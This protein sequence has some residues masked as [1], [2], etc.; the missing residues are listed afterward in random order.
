MKKFARELKTDFK[1]RFS[2]RARFNLFLFFFILPVTILT[3]FMSYT[4]GLMTI[5]DRLENTLSDQR[6][7]F[8]NLKS[9]INQDINDVLSSVKSDLINGYSPNIDEIK[10]SYPGINQIVVEDINLNQEYEQSELQEQQTIKGSSILTYLGVF[11]ESAAGFFGEILQSRKLPE[12]IHDISDPTRTFDLFSKNGFKDEFWRNMDLT[13]TDEMYITVNDIVPTIQGVKFISVKVNLDFFDTLLKGNNMNTLI[14]KNEK[15]IYPK[16]L[17]D[18]EIEKDVLNDKMKLLKTLPTFNKAF[19]LDSPTLETNITDSFVKINDNYYFISGKEPLSILNSDSDE[20]YILFAIDFMQY[21]DNFISGFVFSLALSAIPIIAIFIFSILYRKSILDPI[22][23]LAKNLENMDNRS[24]QP[25][26][27]INKHDE[28]GLI[29]HVF[30]ENLEEIQAYSEELQA[31]NEELKISNE[32]LTDMNKLLTSMNSSL[33]SLVSYQKKSRFL[34]KMYEEIKS[35]LPI[36]KMVMLTQKK[37]E[38]E[39]IT[40]PIPFDFD[41][42]KADE[43]LNRINSDRSRNIVSVHDDKTIIFAYRSQNLDDT[44]YLIKLYLSDSL[45]EEN[46]L[47]VVEMYLKTIMSMLENRDLS[48]EIKQSYIY[49][50]SKLTEISEIYDDETGEHI[51]RVSLYSRFVSEKLGLAKELIQEIEVFSQLHDIGKLKVPYGILT[52]NAKLTEEEYEI[53]K[54]HSEYGADFIGDMSWLTT[55]RNIALN[56]H[57]KYDG[58]GYPGGLKGESIPVE[59][60]IVAIADVYDALRSPRRYKPAFPHE[61][62][63]DIILNGDGRTMPEHF[64]PEILR[65]F[66]ENNEAFKNIYEE[67]R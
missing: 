58:S 66:R 54:K 11:A 20:A 43:V 33:V 26:P 36:G 59:A 52:K 42:V 57:E 15:I 32:E 31:S 25:I 21:V 67:N 60:R 51:K 30:N 44:V 7:S 14:I 10:K 55:A 27:H 8:L 13:G 37:G 62:T 53:I 17:K 9:D 49:L 39:F 29:Y 2:I 24:L 22:L 64:D 18:S 65:I 34:D 4:N 40:Y 1:I 16:I 28:I 35:F 23:A 48:W 47:F 45:P 38:E 56:H 63:M 6:T 61:K 46:G 19:D 50:S 5:K 3:I 41:R 12:L